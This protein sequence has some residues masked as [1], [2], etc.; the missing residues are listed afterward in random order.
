M[1]K[2]K[3]KPEKVD[4]GGRKTVYSSSM[5]KIASEAIRQSGASNRDIAKILGVSDSTIRA[6]MISHK[7]FGTAISEAREEFDTGEI[8]RSM[9]SKAKGHVQLKVVRELRYVGPK[10]PKNISGMTKADLITWTKKKLGINV[11][12][13]LTV[14]AIKI[15]IADE[16]E[17]KTTEKMVVV[18][19]ETTKL[20]GSEAAAQMALSNIG[21]KKKRWN[22]KQQHELSGAVDTSG[23][24]EKERKALK[25]IAKE[26]AKSI[27][28]AK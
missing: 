24:T 4:K 14:K 26:R 17:D 21:D 20:A 15:L 8:Q 22:F 25:Q 3:T 9:I 10:G 23:I 19:K 27:V 1:A 5:D 11:S 28:K 2:N 6:W 13:K 12:K 18:K 7:T 16:I